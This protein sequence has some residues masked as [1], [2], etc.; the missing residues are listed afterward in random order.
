M[1]RSLKNIWALCR[2]EKVL[3]LD[4]IEPI[5]AGVVFESVMISKSLAWGFLKIE[6]LRSHDFFLHHDLPAESVDFILRDDA[7]QSEANVGYGIGSSRDL[8]GLKE[9]S[10]Q[11]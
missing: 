9:P 5:E 3:P 7:P 10:F 1:E 11:Y 4:S 8:L 2:S 6:W